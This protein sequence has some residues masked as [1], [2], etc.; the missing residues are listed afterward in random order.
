[1]KCSNCGKEFERVTCITREKIEMKDGDI[2]ICFGCGEVYQLRNG[3]LELI[4]IKILPVETQEVVKGAIMV[5]HK[6]KQ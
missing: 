1:M 5:L 3:V 2:S 4:D 6:V